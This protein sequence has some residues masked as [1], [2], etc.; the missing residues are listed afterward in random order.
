MTENISN[1][2]EQ[3]PSDEHQHHVL[4]VDDDSINLQLMEGIFCQRPNILLETTLDPEVGIEIAQLKLPDLILLDISMPVLDG[5]QVLEI[6]QKDPRTSAIPVFAVTANAMENDVKRGKT[7]GFIHYLTKP[8]DVVKL[9][10]HID[11][12]LQ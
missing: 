10:G 3:Q 2:T 8:L 4:Y 6:L 11:D 1:M 5:F 12:I 9:L 7:A